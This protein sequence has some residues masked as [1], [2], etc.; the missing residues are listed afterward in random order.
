MSFYDIG[1]S[2]AVW[3]LT[4]VTP[5]AKYGLNLFFCS[6]GPFKGTNRRTPCADQGHPFSR[7]YSHT[8]MPCGALP[9]LRRRNMDREEGTG[10]A[11][12]SVGFRTAS[13]LVLGECSRQRVRAKWKIV[14]YVGGIGGLMTWDDNGLGDMGWTGVF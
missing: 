7:R 12:C 4:P 8:Y 1:K 2:L 5:D 9:P 10:G 13:V 6:E 14:F 3:A 11:D